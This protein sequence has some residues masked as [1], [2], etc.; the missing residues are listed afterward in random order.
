MHSDHTPA[1]RSSATGGGP[2]LPRSREGLSDFQWKQLLRD[3]VDALGIRHVSPKSQYAG[4]IREQADARLAED[5]TKKDLL[6]A[7]KAARWEAEDENRPSVNSVVRDLTY[8]WGK[9]FQP[10]LDRYGSEAELREPITAEGNGTVSAPR[11]ASH[12][13][14][15]DALARD[16]RLPAKSVVLYLLLLSHSHNKTKQVYLSHDRMADELGLDGRQ[17]A[18][19]VVRHLRPLLDCGYIALLKQGR[20]NIGPSSYQIHLGPMTLD[21]EDDRRG[22]GIP[23]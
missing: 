8:I 21:M 18:K 4:R 6:Q 10:F 9:G 19:K 7:A 22:R 13:R 14:V 20:R 16:N 17:R 1:R 23:E 12:N 15:P 11:W 3:A 5:Y 2:G